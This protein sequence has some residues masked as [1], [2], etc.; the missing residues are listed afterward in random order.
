MGVPKLFNSLIN[1]YHHNSATNPT[2]YYVIKQKIENDY[3]THLYLDFNGAIYQCIKPEIKTEDALIAHVVDYLESICEMIPNLEFVYIAMDGIPPMGKVAQQRIRRFHSICKNNRIRK[4][5]QRFGTELD[6]TSINEHIDTN[7]ITP[8]TAFMNN[9]SIAI[10]RKC[11]TFDKW[12]VVFSDSSIPGEGEHKIVKY[13][14]D[15]EQESGNVGNAVNT[16]IYALDGDLIFLSLG[17]HLENTYLFREANEY[18]NLSALT[19]QTGKRFLYMDINELEN[20]IITHSQD[21]YGCSNMTSPDMRRRYIDDYIFLGMLL[22]N[23]FMPKCHWFSIA[24]GG[25]E[26]LLSAYWQIHNHTET[27]LTDCRNDSRTPLLYTEMLGDILFIVKNQETEAI[28]S[29]FARRKKARIPIKSDMTERER[30]QTMMDFLPLQYLNIER[31]I[32]PHMEGWRARYYRTCFNMV[33]STENIQMICR[34][35]L[36][37]LMWN[38]HY[39]FNPDGCIS[40]D[41]VYDFPYCPTWSDIYDELITHK[42][43]NINVSGSDKLFKFTLGKPLDAQTLLFMVLPWNSRKY[44]AVEIARKLVDESCPMRIYFPK[45]YGLNVAFQRYYHE[46]TPI[47]FKMDRQYVE[48]WLKDCKYSEDELKR[49]QIGNVFT[50]RT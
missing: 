26:R 15:Q 40:W 18:G 36:K 22:G 42:N 12:R 9:L 17:L 44:M 14:R 46:C 21:T 13:I 5:N 33:P 8:G 27:Y 30:Q 49:N 28:N 6:H 35:Y 48:K 4:I 47:L 41:W 20:A 37:T 11:M 29:L 25:F 1:Q 7:M 45:R 2:G 24:E 38:F 31:E 10:R 3:P 32:E 19:S 39:Y 50:N 34:S 23:D 43:I 16:V